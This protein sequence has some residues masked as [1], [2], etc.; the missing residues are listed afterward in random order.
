MNLC[1]KARFGIGN[2]PLVN[3]GICQIHIMAVSR[4]KWLSTKAKAR[5]KVGFMEKIAPHG[6]VEEQC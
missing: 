5:N 4:R 1:S 6:A 2:K 3:G